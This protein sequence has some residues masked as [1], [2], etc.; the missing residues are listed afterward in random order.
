MRYLNFALLE[1]KELKDAGLKL[2]ILKWEDFKLE[3]VENHKSLKR[4]AIL[5]RNE[6]T[7]ITGF[8][9]LTFTVEKASAFYQQLKEKG[10]SFA[11]PLRDSKIN[12]Q[13]EFFILL[14]NENNWLQFIG[15]K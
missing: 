14:D 10:S 9:K 6:A 8:T 1:K 11:V 5:K 2:A 15:P 4:N 3:L 7:E 13:E 12:P